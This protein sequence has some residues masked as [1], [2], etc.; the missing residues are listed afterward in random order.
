MSAWKAVG[1]TLLSFLSGCQTGKFLTEKLKRKWDI[2]ITIDYIRTDEQGKE[3]KVEVIRLDNIE[4]KIL[5]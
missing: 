5:P 1:L 4:E 3:Y 2:D